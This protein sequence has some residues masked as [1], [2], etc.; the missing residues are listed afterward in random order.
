[1]L[2][3]E[4]KK[5]EEENIQLAA[6]N[7]EEKNYRLDYEV[8]GFATVIRIGGGKLAEIIDSDKD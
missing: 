6:E 1:M 3:I 7:Q 2:A 5:L 8:E 4:N